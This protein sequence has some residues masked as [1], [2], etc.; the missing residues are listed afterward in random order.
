MLLAAKGAALFPA[1][2]WRDPERGQ[3]SESPLTGLI[4]T[5]PFLTGDPAPLNVERQRL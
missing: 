2:H 1:Q 3:R 5:T 4:N